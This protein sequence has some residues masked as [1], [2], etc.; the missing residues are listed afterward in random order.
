MGFQLS[1]GI[2]IS[3]IDLT[4]IIPAVGTTIG[5][6]ASIFK[7]GPTNKPYLIDSELTLVS[8]FGQ[9]DNIV[10]SNWFTAANFLAYANALQTV[11][12]IRET[13]VTGTGAIATAVASDSTTIVVDVTFGGFGYGT[14]PPLVVLTGGEGIYTQAVATV[15][16]GVVTAVTV[17]GAEGY[18]TGDTPVVA[19]ES[20]T[21][22]HSNATSNGGYVLIQ[23]DDNYNADFSTG[24]DTFVGQWAAKYPGDLG[25][26]LAV[27]I[28]DVNSYGTWAYK[29]Y[30]DGAP[31]TS[32]QVAL[33]GGAND[34]LHAVVID[35]FGLFPGSNGTPGTVLERF[36][37]MSKSVDATAEDGSTMFYPEVMN[38]QSLYVWWMDF[39]SE[40][41][42]GIDVA[43]NWGGDN[44]VDYQTMSTKLTLGT[45]TGDFTVGE[46]VENEASVTVTP[47]GSGAMVA[48]SGLV[49]AGTG[50]IPLTP[51]AGG[52]GYG[53]AP[54]VT[55]V[56]GNGTYSTAVA[57]VSGG[58][59]TAVNV[60]VLT[61]YT[62]TA[63]TITIISPGSGATAT[64][65]VNSLGVITA[66][67]PLALGT[68]YNYPP[69]VTINGPGIDASVVANLGSGG[70]ATKVVSYTVTDG[71]SSWETRSA[72]VISWNTPI[73]E[74]A[75]T[76]GAFDT[77][78]IVTGVVSGAFGTVTAVSGGPLTDTL[79]GG[80]DG[81]PNVED[82]DI[83]TGYGYFASADN[84]DISL[85]LTGPNDSTVDIYLIND[86][87]E[88]RKDCVVFVS[89]P[90]AAVVNNVGNE[91]TDVIAFRNF[92]PSSSYA[93]MD[94]GW[95]YQYDKYNDLY[96]WTPLNGDIAGLCVNTDMVRDPWWSPAGYNRGF[97]K[98]VIKLAWN[99]TKAF[100]DELYQNGVNPVISQPGQGTLLFGDKT[101]LSKPSA[102]DRI[103]VRRL[104][105]VLE[106]AIATA[107]KFTLFEFNDVFTRAQFVSMVEPF[108]RD[109]QGRRGISSYLVV[110]DTTNNTPD[111]IDSNSF[112]GDIYVAPARSINFIQLNFIAVRTGV[113]FT[114]IVG[115]V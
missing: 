22:A 71:G 39:P 93:F 95:K 104:F 23:N 41:E 92:L 78:D 37:F 52:T 74:V 29:N 26:S 81:N 56:G 115:Q 111:V 34:E 42:L 114:E 58:A 50:V 25:N 103:N 83:I 75:P 11:R 55:V 47:S 97:I 36:A 16:D 19:F 4:G 9:P 110:C 45:I 5:A 62:G 89:P 107:A 48:G 20:I 35:T 3:E 76:A 64:V 53:A 24:E 17:T 10:A 27:S 102:F 87:A 15:V 70:N 43:V 57:T 31:N 30:F 82:G 44:T 86:I 99:P 67:T 113:D 6:F 66:V 112:V 108:L 7:W 73:L 18:H 40:A 54:V 79:S 49:G 59:V 12:V 94:S 109:V 69:V 60:T 61:P 88:V 46:T 72:T 8:T 84:I 1:P 14:T 77:S 65:T 33:Q 98:N 51:S 68:G 106:K 32:Q 80:F 2:Q 38:R 105:I 91:A 21:G 96:R 100:R 90:Q 101:M 13:G 63:P 28:A 85:I